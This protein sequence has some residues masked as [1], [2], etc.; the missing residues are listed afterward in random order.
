MIDNLLTSLH[1]CLFTTPQLGSR[2]TVCTTVFLWAGNEQDI[3]ERT[4]VVYGCS[5][6]KFP[7]RQGYVRFQIKYQGFVVVRAPMPKPSARLTWL[8]NMELGGFIPS[9][10]A[11]YA[12]LRVMA[13]P[14]TIGMK[15]EQ[16]DPTMASTRRQT[17]S[18]IGEKGRD[19]SSDSNS[20]KGELTARCDSEG[21]DVA[22]P[23]A[24]ERER[25]RERERD[26]NGALEASLA[27]NAELVTKIAKLEL[28]LSQLR[29]R[30]SFHHEAEE[31]SDL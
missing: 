23:V 12:M 2:D 20:A 18:V 29:K 9:A 6:D 28:E 3:Q 22:N 7:R 11:K 1:R 30:H 13:R 31:Q 26:T 21:A 15:I 10:F 14:R 17:E 27:V 8:A 24:K 25:E 19:N 16:W 4:F 5:L